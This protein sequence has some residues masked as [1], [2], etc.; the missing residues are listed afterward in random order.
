LKL[1][2][3]LFSAVRNYSTQFCVL[4][5]QE[6]MTTTRISY[7]L[8]LVLVVFLLNAAG[9][10][11]SVGNAQVTTNIT[12]SGL[13]TAINGSTS[14][15]CVGGTCN[16]TGGIQKGSNLFHSFG[17][18][19]VGAG[20]TANFCNA[21][22]CGVAQPLGGIQN[23]LGRVTGGQVSNIFGTIQTTSFG[24]AN[25]F[26]MNPNG[27]IL[28]P[29]ARLNVGGSF[30]V[31]TAD[32][33]R[34]EDGSRFN[35]VPSGAD[36]L[37]TVAPPSAFG[38]LTS[39]PAAIAVQ[40][41]TFTTI[42]LGARTLSLVGGPVNVGA[43]PGQPGA[44]PFVFVP[45]GV[46]NITS[47]ASPGEA[48]FA[49]GGFNVDAFAKL[50]E[51]HITG[52]AI[53][54]GREINIRGGRLEITDAILFPGSS[55]LTLAPGLPPPNGGQVSIHVTGDV[56]I[57]GTGRTLIAQGISALPGIQTYAGSPSGIVLQGDVPSVNIRAGSL[58]MSGLAAIQTN[59]YGPGNLP[60]V[61][62]TAET[63]EIR[64]GAVIGM[65]NSF[66]GG[67]SPRSRGA[68]DINGIN[69]TLSSDGSTRFTGIN[70]D[71]VFHPA[72]GAGAG[73]RPE[74]QSAESPSV[75]I[76]MTGNFTVRGNAGITTDSLSFGPAGA[77]NV[78][79]ANIL[80]VGAGP[81]TG[82]VSA[83]GGIVGQSGNISLNATGKIDV[84]N[85]FRVSA[86]AGGSGNGGIV[87]LAAGESITLGANSRILSGT[88]PLQDQELNSF[89]RRFNG[90]FQATHGIPIPD[91]V[92]LRKALGVAP[93]PGDLMQVLAELNKITLAGNP[94]VAVTDFT[95]GEAGRIS[96]TTPLLT[97][98]AE[99]RI[100]TSTGW[101]G[102]A[103]NI[104]LNVGNFTQVGGARVDSSTLGAGRGGEVTVTAD[105]I[106]ISG[107]GTGLFSTASGSGAGGNIKIQAGQLVQLTD[108]GTIS[109]QSTG[110]ATATAGNININA[111]TFQSQNGSVRTGAT[112]ANGGNISISTTGSL[113]HLTDSQITTSVLG[114]VGNGGDIEIDSKLIVMNDSQILARA[115][116]GHGGNINIT[117]DVFLMNTG[118]RA[119]V[120]LNGIIDASSERNTPEIDIEATFTDVT[121]S[122]TRLPETPLQATAL[123]RASCTARFAGGKASSLVLGGRDG[124]PLQ[125]GDLLPSPLYMAGPSSG[126]NRLTGEEMPLRFTLRESKD[127]LLN[128]YSLLP[129]AKCSL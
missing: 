99:A 78:N 40:T 39:N 59:R 66:G 11:L 121:G 129:N 96:I 128:K 55:S 75:T 7:R 116:L 28:G 125:P 127:R 104:S 31:T 5:R 29:T 114:G 18:L 51:I 4:G 108:G 113:V 47:V 72:Y 52:G 43:A 103:G 97:M 85:G 54:D 122:V 110:T 82:R 74:L 48:T 111:P 33:I 69:M 41:G 27:W 124:L 42:G 106:S 3:R 61:E 10:F 101:G 32:Y 102:N 79:A 19:N 17:A 35:A 119:P 91:Y 6:E 24:A 65:S 92:S 21:A 70:T 126:D 46:V 89:A 1:A 67:A 30:H 20:N 34:L 90:F 8:H 45:G 88:S 15:P 13:G 63:I 117:G 50:G 95:P 73:F 107:P 68:V 94:L 115:V 80:L 71:P 23:I 56:T 58:S 86:G 16:I 22:T 87:A 12:S 118:G 100:E 77:I 109:A 49:G 37:V 2:L 14:L 57:T 81:E 98:N 38:F 36:A 93:A 25:L 9:M 64:N 83:Q 105:S 120:L 53:V 62:I 76:N 26:L 84:Q 60:T 123:L 112:L 44:G